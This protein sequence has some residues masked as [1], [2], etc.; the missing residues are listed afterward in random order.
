MSEN[1][2]VAFQNCKDYPISIS[3][4]FKG[5]S[6]KFTLWR[7]DKFQDREGNPII[8]DK[9]EWPW[10]LRMGIKPIYSNVEATKEKPSMPHVETILDDAA[11]MEAKRKAV[12][13][14]P[15]A[16]EFTETIPSI[17]I[18]EDLKPLSHLERKDNPAP[19]KADLVWQDA[20]GLWTFNKDGRQN[21]NPA[22]IKQYIKKT[23]GDDYLETV[24]WVQFSAKPT[25]SVE[26]T[27]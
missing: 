23:F 26:T 2:V 6:I 16:E 15:V 24:E 22:K 5:R 7:D 11:L 21:L 9:E 27:T 17:E 10:L 18:V 12:S 25:S 13:M 1:A 4:K 14:P 19:E 8:P 20:D 3:V